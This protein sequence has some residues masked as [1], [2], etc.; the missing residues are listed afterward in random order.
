MHVV[1]LWP[2]V[3]QAR[4]ASLGVDVR[5]AMPGTVTGFRMPGLDGP[6]VG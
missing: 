4:A 5:P 2:D 1:P 3:R 6:P